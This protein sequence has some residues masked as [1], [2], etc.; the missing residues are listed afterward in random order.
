MRLSGLYIISGTATG[1]E[2]HTG[3]GPRARLNCRCPGCS[4]PTRR[5]GQAEQLSELGPGDP[6]ARPANTRKALAAYQK[7]DDRTVWWADR[8]GGQHEGRVGVVAARKRPRSGAPCRGLRDPGVSLFPYRRNNVDPFYRTIIMGLIAR[9]LRYPT[10]PRI[11]DLRDFLGGIHVAFDPAHCPGSGPARR[12]QT[13]SLSLCGRSA[14]RAHNWS[15]SNRPV[16][17]TRFDWCK[18]RDS[19][20]A[21]PFTV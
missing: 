14:A 19:G 4:L 6:A 2:G 15:S 17:M 9:P 16:A 11:G 3:R 21:D 18:C 13:L 8:D 20:F 7:A 1:S 5:Y 10:I 12:H